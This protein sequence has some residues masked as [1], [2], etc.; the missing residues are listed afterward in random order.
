MQDPA[1]IANRSLDA[2]GAPERIGTLLDG[3][4]V[5]E[6]ARRAYGPLLRQLL[7]AAHWNFSRKSAPL[8]LLGD[9]TGATL[10]PRGNPI[11]NAVES[12]WTY[13]YAW[14]PDALKARWMPYS[15]IQGMPSPPLLTNMTA[16]PPIPLMPT[17]FL[18]STSDQ[19]PVP[20]G[21]A[22]VEGIGLTERKIVLA[23]Q[24][25]ALLVYTKLVP[26]IEMWDP[27]FAEAMVAVMAERLAM[28][29]IRDRKEAIAMRN[30]QIAIAKGI[31][32]DARV[33]DGNEGW[34]TTDHIPDWISG[35]IGVL[36]PGWPGGPGVLF[37]G[38]DAFS[39]SAGSA[40]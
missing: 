19:F 2:L 29:A 16:N 11:S 14:P 26:T 23:D 3:T 40:F 31:I 17:R 38:W 12:P 30:A 20:V 6:A 33:S 25:N 37:Y 10:D 13:A 22:T 4:D 34:E 24:Q 39:F 28:V 27:L 36:G 7:R 9:A 21:D 8:E 1:D 32:A 5:S 35:R 15:G 18:V